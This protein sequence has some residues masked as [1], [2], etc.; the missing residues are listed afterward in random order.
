[1]FPLTALR[2]VIAHFP[3]ADSCPAT[4][5]AGTRLFSEIHP[6]HE[7]IMYYFLQSVLGLVPQLLHNTS[8]NSQISHIKGI[9]GSHEC[10]PW[11]RDYL[12]EKPSAQG[13]KLLNLWLNARGTFWCVE[14]MFQLVSLLQKR[15]NSFCNYT[16]S[17][18]LLFIW[19]KTAFISSSWQ[20]NLAEL[21]VA[22]II[23]PLIKP[24]WL[25]S[26]VQLQEERT[27]GLFSNYGTQLLK[28]I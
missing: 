19:C 5:S 2:R 18:R 20:G 22:A 11:T 16:D 13:D 21:S 8:N 27:K 25:E 15:K 23:G 1:M 9:I 7:Q 3:G 24:V 17:K 26:R 28:T 6:P 10:K 14:F 4:S 12:K